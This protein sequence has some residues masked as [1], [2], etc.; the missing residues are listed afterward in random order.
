MKILVKQEKALAQD[1]CSDYIAGSVLYCRNYLFL[2]KL[3]CKVWK[4]LG[5]HG[6]TTKVKLH[7]NFKANCGITTHL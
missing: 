4:R 5:N 1:N 2:R 3:S 7:S 6:V